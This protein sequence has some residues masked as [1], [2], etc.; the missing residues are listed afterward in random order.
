MREPTNS[1]LERI[2]QRLTDRRVF[3]RRR[4]PVV[5]GAAGLAMQSKAGGFYIDVDPSLTGEDLLRVF[6]HEAAHIKRNDPTP[7]NWHNE[8]SGCI[9]NP[10]VLAY[11]AAL[12]RE[13][14]T[15][16]LA[17]GWV[18]F[19]QEHAPEY[20]GSPWQ[21]LCKWQ[22]PALKSLIDQAVKTGVAMALSRLE[23]KR[24]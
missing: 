19:A 2:V 23:I 6:C 7:S 20:G 12:P 3:V 18:K 4:L 24:R 11:S 1:D 15:D 22:D 17:A 8:P 9:K 14:E 21:A 16:R 10:V 5:Q 13:T